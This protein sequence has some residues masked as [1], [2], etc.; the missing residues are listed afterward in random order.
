[1]DQF[2]E[3]KLLQKG[4]VAKEPV[5]LRPGS[6]GASVAQLSELKLLQKGLVAQEPIQ[7]S[8]KE[9]NNSKGAIS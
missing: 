8:F 1:M 3:L 4:F 6:Q 5:Q 7:L 2:S 9:L